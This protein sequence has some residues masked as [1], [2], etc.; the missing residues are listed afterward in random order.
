MFELEESA[1]LRPDGISGSGVDVLDELRHVLKQGGDDNG[2]G[3]NGGGKGGD[4]NGSGGGEDP[5][6][7]RRIDARILID[8]LK[9]MAQFTKTIV[10]SAMKQ[11]ADAASETTDFL[12]D[13]I[14]KGREA[15][16]ERTLE[17][18]KQLHG[19]SLEAIQATTRLAQGIANRFEAAER[20][21]DAIER[22]LARSRSTNA[23]AG[24]AAGSGP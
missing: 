22:E 10:L 17:L 24:D 6:M 13:T 2:S 9:Q 19:T 12:T 11:Q 5:L 3:N 1:M 23:A 15:D 16:Q 14:I 21:L 20:R 7:G 8:S 18:A 4:G